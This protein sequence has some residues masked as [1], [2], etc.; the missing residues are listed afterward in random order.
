M[1]SGRIDMRIPPASEVQPST[2]RPLSTLKVRRVLKSA[3]PRLYMLLRHIWR[4]WLLRE[5]VDRAKLAERF[6]GNGNPR[7]TTGPFEGMVYLGTA[8][9]SVLV[10][11]LVGCYEHDLHGTIEEIIQTSYDT[12]INVGCAEG[13]YAVGL[14]LR[15]PAAKIVAVDLD[16]RA[17]ELCQRLAHLNGVGTRVE[18]LNG[19]CSETLRHRRYPGALW[20]VDCEGAELDILSPS[21]LPDLLTA[22]ILVE[23]HDFVDPTISGILIGRFTDTHDVRLIPETPTPAH[24]YPVL[25]GLTKS[26]IRMAVDERRPGPM[27]WAWMRSRAREQ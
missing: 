20:V 10:P 12:V 23:L 19:D 24:D 26:Q 18:T 1:T 16:D 5:S 21:Q 15:L 14:A 3:T 25:S 6:L 13:Y 22:D 8:L 17:C 2:T 7:V 9:G 4:D 27:K 11:K